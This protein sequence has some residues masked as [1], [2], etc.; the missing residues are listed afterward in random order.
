MQELIHRKKCLLADD[1]NAEA[2]DPN[3]DRI[4][5]ENDDKDVE[6]EEYK[7]GNE[8]DDK[9]NDDEEEN[10]GNENANAAA[11]QTGTGSLRRRL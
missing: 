2:E 5:N 10:T 9:D 8:T 3:G 11:P 7:Y 4:C 1:P 6:D